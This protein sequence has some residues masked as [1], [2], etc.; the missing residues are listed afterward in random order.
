MARMHSGKKGKSGSKKP[1]SAKKITWQRYDKNEL[2]Q[3][4]SKLAKAQ[5]SHSQIG[6]ILRDSYG[7]PSVSQ[8]TGKSITQILAEEKL[9]PKL[10]EDMLNLIRKYINITKHLQANRKDQPSVRGLQLTES[11]IKRLAKYYKANDKLPQDWRFSRE[12]ASLL[13]E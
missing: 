12:H 13:I 6:I 3:L 7:I 4:I 9:L 1:L 10:P 8:L 11:K 5:K 2:T